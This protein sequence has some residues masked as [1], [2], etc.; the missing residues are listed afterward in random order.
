MVFLLGVSFYAGQTLFNVDDP[1]GDDNGAG[2][3][4]YPKNNKWQ[5]GDLDLIAVAAESVSGGTWFHTKFKNKIKNPKHQNRTMDK[6][7]P[8]DFFN[9]N[10]DFYFDLDGKA[11]SGHTWTVPGRNVEVHPDS[12]WEK[13]VI[14]TPRPNIAS[15][16]MSSRIGSTSLLD[17]IN[18]G[19][20]PDPFKKVDKQKK[21]DLKNLMY[22]PTKIKV[23]N[24]VLSFFVPDSFFGSR[25]KPEWKLVGFVTA[26]DPMQS[27]NW[28]Q[29]GD[30]PPIMMVPVNR[31]R[32]KD[33]FGSGNINRRMYPAVIDAFYVNATHQKQYL[34][35][36]VIQLP[37][38]LL[39]S[40]DKG[41]EQIQGPDNKMTRVILKNN[42]INRDKIRDVSKDQNKNKSEV[43]PHVDEKNNSDF[44][45]DQEDQLNQLRLLL[46]ELLRRQD[47]K[48][49][50]NNQISKENQHNEHR[51][52]KIEN[53]KLQELL[54]E[55]TKKQQNK[56][57]NP[58][59]SKDNQLDDEDKTKKPIN[60][61]LRELQKL[62]KE[63]L[64]SKA[65][66]ER[67]RKK[68]LSEI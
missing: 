40:P 41:P 25:L 44:N 51:M 46:E 15:Q 30:A 37:G 42:T 66:Y 58:Q 20:S 43:K 27:Q 38:V 68:I 35:G 61:R 3:V 54:N 32:P 29:S 22:F 19:F 64:I 28:N 52:Q 1:V 2:Y 33:R 31:G 63:K 57:V 18:K 50:D 14:L 8:F 6:A 26:C 17:Q 49:V 16:Q 34:N 13:A 10:I 67:L 47:D 11:N 65:E 48:K 45:Q 23:R 62:Y 39:G 56:E 36:D 9:I 7:I 4:I 24:Q 59:I 5:K 55:L 12:G 60:Q 21:A 53:K